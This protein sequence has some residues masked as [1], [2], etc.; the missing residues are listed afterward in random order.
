[1]SAKIDLLRR[2]VLAQVQ[3]TP[4]ADAIDLVIAHRVC[5]SVAR[6]PAECVAAGVAGFCLRDHI[7]ELDDTGL[8]LA[9]RSH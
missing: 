8:D 6:R 9:G 3:S 7:L 1:M 4:A 2:H 5:G